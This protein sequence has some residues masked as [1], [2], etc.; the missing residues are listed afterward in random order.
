MM[1]CAGDLLHG[2]T[3]LRTGAVVGELRFAVAIVDT[4][5]R[6]MINN[7]PVLMDLSQGSSSAIT[8][9]AYPTPSCFSHVAL[10]SRLQLTTTQTHMLH[11]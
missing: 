4:D 5:I 6:R 3:W 1:C 8:Y 2:G 9:P 10:C 11:S 7:M